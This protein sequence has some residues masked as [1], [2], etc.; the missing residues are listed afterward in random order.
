MGRVTTTIGLL[1][2]IAVAFGELLFGILNDVFVVY[3]SIFVG[4]IGVL[5]GSFAYS[6]FGKRN[7][8]A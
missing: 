4:A 2:M 5:L 1:S 8:T 3:V 6:A 7:I